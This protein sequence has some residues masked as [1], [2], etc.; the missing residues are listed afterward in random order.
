[1]DK[2]TI[3]KYLSR[4]LCRAHTFVFE[5]VQIIRLKKSVN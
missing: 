2:K 4:D 3:E 5:F 1:V